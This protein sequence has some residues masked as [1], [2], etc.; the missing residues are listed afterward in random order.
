MMVERITLQT[1]GVQSNSQ[2]QKNNRSANTGGASFD[3]ALQAQL[4]RPSAIHFSNHAQQRLEARNIDLS[5]DETM[6]LEQAVDKAAAKGSRES[7]ILMN[8]L[9]F[10][11]SVKNRTVITAVDADNRK[12]NVFTNI[13]SVVLT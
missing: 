12:E 11:V 4:G 10:I 3:E 13:D 7:L 6:R 5:G 8:D 1:P 9:A 2:A